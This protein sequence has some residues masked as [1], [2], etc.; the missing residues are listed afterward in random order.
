MK[1]WTINI[2]KFYQISLLFIIVVIFCI[3]TIN[4]KTADSISALV[5]ITFVLNLFIS[6][7]SF[8]SSV[9][10]H[11]YSFCVM[12]WLFNF[13]FLCIAPLVQYMADWTSW[14]LVT[15][16]N[17]I[18]KCNLLITLWQ[19]C[20]YIGT[21]NR[22]RIKKNRK[23]QAG[24]PREVNRWGILTVFIISFVFTSILFLTNGISGLLLRGARVGVSENSTLSLLFFHVFRNTILYTFVVLILAVKKHRS[25]VFLCVFACFMFLL[26]CFPTSISRYM[27]GAF[28]L[29]LIIIFLGKEKCSIWYTSF[30]FLGLTVAFP[31]L[32]FFRNLKTLSAIYSVREIVK[33]SITG[34]YLTGNYDAHN[35]IISAFHYTDTFGFSYGKQLIGALL[36][37]VPRSIWPGKPIGTGAT[38][39]SSLQQSSFTNVSMP[40][41]GESYINFGVVGVVFFAVIVGSVVS[42]IDRAYWANKDDFRII[43]I[44]Y[45]FVIFYFFFLQ[46]GDMMSAG[47]YLIANAVVGVLIVKTST[48]NFERSE[49]NH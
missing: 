26:A 35:M 45:P 32:S 28:Y 3:V 15:T 13:V 40:F 22:L 8:L 30:V 27:A 36:F 34:T 29:G 9:K 12:F 31:V 25:P 42:R 49:Y 6:F 24:F 47:A 48:K 37:F 11:P 41:I 23:K 7:F 2:K 5:I 44:I 18:I 21:K 39:V 14:G 16:D 43:N 10:T 1:K 19:L 33:T 46:R 4:K 20:F 17:E 38:V